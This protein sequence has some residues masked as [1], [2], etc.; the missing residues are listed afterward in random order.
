MNRQ[1]FGHTK[2]IV[3]QEIDKM[4]III[5]DVLKYIPKGEFKT[6]SQ[7]DTASDSIGSNF[8]E[9]YYSGSLGEYIRF[10]NYAKRSNGE[11]HERVRRIFRKTYISEE[12]YNKFEDNCIRVM[13][14]LDRTIQSLQNKKIQ[15]AKSAKPS[16]TSKS[17]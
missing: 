5:Q 17:Y 7:I 10:L 11:L 3:W 8:V 2:M 16:K 9:G 12:L 15:E 6:K 13:Y 1:G 14:L 4:D